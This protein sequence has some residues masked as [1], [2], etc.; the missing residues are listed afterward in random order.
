MKRRKFAVIYADPSWWYDDKCHAGQRGAEY[1]YPCMRD[2]DVMGLP[3]RSIAADDAALFLWATW[4]KLP[5]ALDVMACWG[6][7]FKTIGFL[8]VKTAKPRR[9]IVPTNGDG[10][11]RLHWGMGHWSRSN[12]EPCLLG[13]RGRPR[14]VSHGVHSVVFAPRAEH[15]AKPPEVRDRIRSLTAAPRIELFLRGPTP[16]GWWGWGNEAQGRLVTL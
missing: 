10:L 8:W 13:V 4:P 12:T 7:T 9:G 6:F 11:P 16:P 3:V 15:S 2:D 14:A 1:V 5:T